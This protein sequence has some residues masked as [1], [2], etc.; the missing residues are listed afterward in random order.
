M[1]PLTTPVA[2]AAACDLLV[3]DAQLI[4]MVDDGRSYPGSAIAV[5]GDRIAEIG[6]T[7]DLERRWRARRVIDAGGGVA[8]PGLIDMHN[9]SP[10]ILVRGMMEDLG[11]APAYTT[12]VPQGH[13]LSHEEVYALSRLGLYE[14]LRGGCTTVVDWYWRGGAIAQAAYES[15]LRAFV[16]SRITDVDTDAMAARALRYDAAIGDETIRQT[17]DLIDRW[18][19]KANGRMRCV[20]GHLAADMSSLDQLRRVGELS[21]AYGLDIHTHL[22]QNEFAIELVRETFGERPVALWDRLGLLDERLK[23]AHCIFVTDDEIAR[24]GS[25]GATVIHVPFG[26]LSAGMVAP[27]VALERAGARIVLSTDTSS[28]DMFDAMRLAVSAARVRGAGYQ[29]TSKDALRWAFRNAAAALGLAGEIGCLVPG[30][31]A[32]LI[33]LER[34]PNITPSLSGAGILVWSGSAMNVRHSIVDGDLVLEDRRPTRFDGDEV[35]AT[36]EAVARRLWARSGRVP[37]AG[38]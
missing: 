9:H 38:A 27:I 12:G 26:N 5:V 3:R 29:V 22:H 28:C 1:N 6:P 10:L 24:I 7:A 25:S 23:A 11:F 36:A 13:V 35:I 21:R 2:P 37:H 34:S 19:M 16:S 30:A 32:D 31:K 15:G 14:L 20:I 4:P 8:M 17:I 18:H 33:V